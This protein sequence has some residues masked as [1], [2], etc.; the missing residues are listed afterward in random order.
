MQLTPL[1][2]AIVAAAFA[3]YLAVGLWAGRTAGGGYED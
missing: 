1:D 3:V 2:W